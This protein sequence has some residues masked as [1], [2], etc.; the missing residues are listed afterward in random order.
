M[1][2]DKDLEFLSCR[3]NEELQALADILI[4]KKNGRKRKFETL[5]DRKAFLANYPN[6]MKELLPDIIDEL[7]RCGGNKI[8]NLFRK[9]DVKYRE[10]LSDVCKKTKVNF[11]KNNTTSQMEIYLLQKMI[12][13]AAD[14]MT[15]EDVKQV[16]NQFEKAEDFRKMIST[17]GK[18]ATPLLIRMTSIIL[19]S[20]SKQIGLKVFA[21]M[22][23]KFVGGRLMTLLSGPAGWVIG[24]LWAVYDCF[25]PSY[26]TLVPA[27]ITISYYRML[28]SASEEEIKEAFE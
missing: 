16:T 26:K 19:V 21:G 9:P 24:S 28:D 25:G 8:L 17:G 4:Y 20:L 12:A 7:K 18:I 11:N 6:N 14:K 13:T 5:T 3:S 15:D 1:D 23:A 10:L 22:I 27:V 2:K